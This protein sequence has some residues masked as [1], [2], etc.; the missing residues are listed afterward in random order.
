M[1]YQ[2]CQ[3]RKELSRTSRLDGE[4]YYVSEE[5]DMQK[6]QPQPTNA[7]SINIFEACLLHQFKILHLK[8]F[9]G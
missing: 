5:E 8:S 7:F 3:A 4:C 2:A 6:K 9:K 1:T